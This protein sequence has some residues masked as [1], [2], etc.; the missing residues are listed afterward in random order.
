MSYLKCWNCCWS[1]NLC[2]LFNFQLKK[3][4]SKIIQISLIIKLWSFISFELRHLNRL[5]VSQNA[6]FGRSFFFSWKLKENKDSMFDDNFNTLN[7]TWTGRKLPN[8]SWKSQDLANI[9]WVLWSEVI[10]YGSQSVNLTNNKVRF[11]VIIMIQK[12]LEHLLDL[13]SHWNQWK[14]KK[15]LFD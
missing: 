2:F 8:Y 5:K 14:C 15:R 3:I 9:S 11:I 12:G 1:W 6:K 13:W 10:N 7:M 4:S